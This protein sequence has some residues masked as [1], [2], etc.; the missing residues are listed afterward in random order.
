MPQTRIEKIAQRYAVG[1]EDGQVVRA[2]DLLAIR[3]KHIMTHDNTGAVIPKFHSIGATKIKDPGQPVFGMDHDVQNTTPENLGKYAK[4]EK[5][6]REQG[7]D[8]YPPGRGIAHQIM[9]EEGYVTPGSF[10][11]G[12]DSHSNLYGAVAALGT[13]VVRTDAAAIWATG[14]TWWQVPEQ[15]NVELTGS[16]RPGATGKDVIIALCGHFNNDEA[17]NGVIEFTGEGVAGLSM[18]ERLTIANMTTEWGALA[19][20]FPF[21]ETLKNYLLQRAELF[22]R[23]GN[24]RYTAADV[25]R[26]WDERR[27]FDSDPGAHYAR[28]MT[29]DL[30]TVSPHVSGPNS[31]KVMTSVHEL[32]A[33]KKAINKAYLMSCVNARLED[34]AA[35]AEVMRGRK[36]APG[37]EFYLAPASSQVREEAQ[38]LGWWQDLLDAGAIELPAGCGACIGLGAGTLEAGEVGISATNR[39]FQGRMGSREALC[40]LASPAVV[41]ASAV[42]GFICAPEDSGDV[43]IRGECVVHKA[44]SRSGSVTRVRDDFPR[45]VTGRALYLPLDNLNTDGI[46][47]KDVT[48]RDDITFEQQGQYAMLNYDPEFQSKAQAGDI[49]VGGRNF[50]SGSSREQAATALA[51]RGVR[52]VIAA[53]FSQ[54]YKRNAFNNGF[55]C[56]DCPALTD[57]LHDSLGDKERTIVG[58]EIEVDFAA[59]VAR[60]SGEEFPFDPLGPVAQELV[61]MGGSEAVVQAQLAG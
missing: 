7:V 13:P 50:G 35:A 5:F 38:R 20:V 10:C 25:E 33:Q 28:T 41:A 1:L 19:G 59:S 34:I 39:N 24:P 12:S 36:V 32:Q 14:Q 17:L 53:S 46:Y 22:E 23:R 3:P 16:L 2:G 54:T 27:G 11:V 55:I 37:V 48:Y 60:M 8:Y 9:V 4:I 40:Y 15:I 31:V 51:S 26:W 57:A 44:P 43:A 21:D 49:I 56:I 61:V 30:S 58:P 52:M 29:L 47:G 18:D 45:T 6:A 42:N